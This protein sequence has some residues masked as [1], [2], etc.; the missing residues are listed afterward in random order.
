MVLT[1]LG[2]IWS[3][4]FENWLRHSRIC[5]SDEAEH[6]VFPKG[7]YRGA[8]PFPWASGTSCS[9]VIWSESVIVLDQIKSRKWV[10]QKKSIKSSNQRNQVILKG[11]H[12]DQGDPIQ[13]C[14]ESKLPCCAKVRW[15][16]WSWIAKHGFSKSISFW[17]R[18]TFF[19]KLGPGYWVQDNP[20]FLDQRYP[21]ATKQV[22]NN[23]YWRFDPDQWQNCDL[24]RFPNLFSSSFEKPIFKI[25]FNP[26]AEIRSEQLEP[27]RPAV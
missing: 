8:G 6:C 17:S 5:V 25:L 11:L 7:F 13:C 19:E 10:V 1:E 2:S 16:T 14:L 18:L 15:I 12:L 27:V 23:T 22:L 4:L 20:D 9:K 3:V 24:I 26:I 21:N